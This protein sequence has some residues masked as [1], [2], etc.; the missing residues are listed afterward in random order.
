MTRS[1]SIRSIT[2]WSG[3]RIPLERRSSPSSGKPQEGSCSAKTTQTRTSGTFINKSCM[4]LPT[5]MRMGWSPRREPSTRF[6][7]QLS[8][9][10]LTS[11]TLTPTWTKFKSMS[12]TLP[13]ATSTSMP[14]RCTPT[15][16]S[17]CKYSITSWWFTNS[18]KKA[19]NSMI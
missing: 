15:A 3:P 13:T 2:T 9:T 5:K 1:T 19:L 7:L 4:M 17:R 8:T 11:S 6:W 18:M 10:S 12:L 14:F 16:W